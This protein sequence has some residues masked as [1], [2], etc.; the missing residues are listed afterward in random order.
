MTSLDINFLQKKL[1]QMDNLLL[2]LHF[3]QMHVI[4]DFND[5]KLADR[6]N[7]KMLLV[8]LKSLGLT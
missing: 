5:V 6:A 2:K 4:E 1:K 8:L 7:F 3:A